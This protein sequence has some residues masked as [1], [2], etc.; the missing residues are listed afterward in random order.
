MLQSHTKRSICTILYMLHN[1]L[2]CK[3]VVGLIT[4]HIEK[5]L[6]PEIQILVERH[7]V[8]CPGCRT[9]LE[10]IQKT[11]RVLREQTKE[12]MESLKSEQKQEILQAFRKKYQT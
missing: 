7:L 10:Q 3:E 1:D 8:E 4:D 9:Y 6:L 12:P 2:T 5:T 11:L